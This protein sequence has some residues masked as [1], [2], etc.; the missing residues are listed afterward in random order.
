MSIVDGTGL[1]TW[2]GGLF[3]PNSDLLRRVQWAFAKIRADGGDIELNEAGRPFGVPG[4]MNVRNAW[5]TA[6]G[7][8]TVWFQWGRYKRGETPS[9]ANPNSG[10]LASEHTQGKAIDC[11]AKDVY[12]ATLRA[13]YFAMVGMKQT[14]SSESWHWA[15]R[16]NPTVDLSTVAGGS[17]IPIPTGDEVDMASRQEIA[18]DTRAVVKEEVA[19]AIAPLL[20]DEAKELDAERRESRLWRLFR[21]T[22]RPG[23]PDEF[24]A[25]AYALPPEDPRQIIYLGADLVGPLKDSYQMT[26]DTAANARPLNARDIATLV[27]MAKGTDRVFETKPSS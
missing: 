27:R 2:E 23:K 19:A 10:A 7:V 16:S 12:T 21:N 9:A 26:A 1:V 25:V 15:I 4:D 13:K 3:E 6:S 5:Q 22:D 8:S 24:V 14:I 11:N 20:D 18:A 17:A